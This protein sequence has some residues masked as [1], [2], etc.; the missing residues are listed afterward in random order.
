MKKKSCFFLLLMIFSCLFALSALA[1]SR[2]YILDQ[3]YEYMTKLDEQTV[4]FASYYG[5]TISLDIS[6]GA[7]TVLQEEASKVLSRIL[8]LSGVLY[9]TPARTP[10]FIPF[11]SDGETIRLDDDTD[12]WSDWYIC[13][14]A[15][16]DGA[17]FMQKLSYSSNQQWIMRYDLATEAVETFE[18]KKDNVDVAVYGYK[19]NQF[20]TYRYDAENGGVDLCIY[21]WD[22]KE[23]VQTLA[24]FPNFPQGLC[25]S[26]TF[27]AVFYTEDNRLMKLPIGGKP[28][29]IAELTYGAKTTVS[30]ILQDRYYII[31]GDDGLV[32]VYDLQGESVAPETLTI[33]CGGTAIKDGYSQFMVD[34]PST[35]I[36]FEDA[37]NWNDLAL[38][39]INREANYDILCLSTNSGDLQAMMEKG[40]FVDLS[41]SE[42]LAQQAMLFYPGIADAVQYDGKLAAWPMELSIFWQNWGCFDG[43]W[44]GVPL[45]ETFDDLLDMLLDWPEELENVK[46]FE[47]DAIEQE[48]LTMYLYRCEQEG[49]DF[50]SPAFVET[51]AKIRQAAAVAE[52]LVDHN[53]PEQPFLFTGD[54]SVWN[55]RL[56]AVPVSDMGIN[57]LYGSLTVCLIHPGSEHI[58]LALEYL[59]ACAQAQAETITLYDKPWGPVENPGY[60]ERVAE[61]QEKQN[62]LEARLAEMP[63]DKDLQAEIQQHEDALEDIE[64]NRYSMTAE[65]IANYRDNIAPRLVFP[66]PSPFEHYGIGA[67]EQMDGLI[68]RYLSGQLAAESFASELSR[69]MQMR[70]WEEQS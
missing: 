33:W 4:V 34:H 45:P 20:L 48:L 64:A 49:V 63:E 2:Q 59:E 38:A 58:D 54:A 56:L 7:V 10:D 47:N 11:V 50:A 27:D 30:V 13:T 26:A 55:Y 42:A 53:D 6:D 70:Y 23:W 29:Q 57:S 17:I 43:R 8:S 5:R 68:K 41:Q 51:L 35:A 52:R 62:I 36:A 46:P 3:N 40:Y 44:S 61:W 25:Y 12:K 24:Y 19:G 9:H 67:D 22:A 66:Q 18:I 16:Q 60:A 37:P 14:S 28:E 65:Q 1:E 21:D 31:H 39:L 32:C 15:C 69:I